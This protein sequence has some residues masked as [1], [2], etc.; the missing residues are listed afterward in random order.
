[1]KKSIA[2][3][4]LPAALIA[5]VAFAQAGDAPD[6]TARLQAAGYAEV[7]D[8]E[9][10][11]GLWEA[12]VRR[13]DGRWGEVAIDAASGEIFDAKD[14]KPMLDARGVAE[15]LEAAGYSEITDLDRDGGLW[16]AEARAQDGTRVELR[17]AGHD[18]RVLSSDVEYDD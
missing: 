13:A 15:A 1:M 16:E 3:S 14:G 17:L 12:E 2:L 5:T 18:G 7:R 8:V 6:V 4:L 10:D 11:G 9:F